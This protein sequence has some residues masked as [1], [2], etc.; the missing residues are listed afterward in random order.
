MLKIK[1]VILITILL[2][3]DTIAQN[4]NEFIS[5]QG[6]V[7][8]YKLD[9][10]LNGKR[11]D[12]Y[13][14]TIKTINPMETDLFYAVKLHKND[15]RKWIPSVVPME[16]SF[17]KIK[18]K[19]S[20]GWF[21]DGVPLIGDKTNI[22]LENDYI[23]FKLEKDKEYS[24]DLFFKVKSNSKPIINNSFLK[25]LLIKDKFDLEFNSKMIDGK[26]MSS[27]DAI[28]IDL[29]FRNSKKKGDYLVQVVNGKEYVW[30]RRNIAT[31][32]REDDSEYWLTFDKR[33][34][35]FSYSSP[36]GTICKW[37]KEYI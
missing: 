6:V 5:D 33:K 25:Y 7:I 17:A 20:L 1:L 18:V 9:L 36:D 27:C 10:L 19:N 30:L 26:Y 22:R 4:K 34:M 15:Q 32:T 31:F 24:Y 8:T 16:R 29:H 28:L 2:V 35:R 21:G 3:A 12:K 11:K 37:N 13:K 23:L 14:L